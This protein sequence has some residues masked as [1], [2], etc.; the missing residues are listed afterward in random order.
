MTSQTSKTAYKFLLAFFVLGLTIS[1]CNNNKDGEKKEPTT[2]TVPKMEPAPPQTI[3]TIP[4]E[5][6]LKPRPTDPG[7]KTVN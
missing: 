5:D 1:A 7:N 3:D 6:T 4:K 2:D